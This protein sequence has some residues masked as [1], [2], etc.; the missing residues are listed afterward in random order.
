MMTLSFEGIFQYR[1]HRHWTNWAKWNSHIFNLPTNIRNIYSFPL[2]DTKSAWIRGRNWMSL[3][4]N[5]AQ[6]QHSLLLSVWGIISTNS[7]LNSC[8][9]N[10]VHQRY[11]HQPLNQHPSLSE[12]KIEQLG[13]HLSYAQLLWFLPLDG[14]TLPSL[15]LIWHH[16]KFFWNYRRN[17][18]ERSIHCIQNMKPDLHW[19]Y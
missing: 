16:H 11:R 2:G 19:C 12:Q 5:G 14:Q 1:G 3:W 7:Q 8:F 13:L 17:L 9:L 10:E 15:V 4:A 6:C 18:D